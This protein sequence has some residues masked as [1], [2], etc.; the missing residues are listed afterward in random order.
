MDI[1]SKK[2]K[3]TKENLVNYWGQRI[4][5]QLEF[6]KRLSEINNGEYRNIIEEVLTFINNNTIESKVISEE[7]ALKAEEKMKLLEEKAK[8]YEV[9]CA[10]HAHIDMN[11]QWRYDETVDITLETFRTVLNLMEEYKEFTFSQSQASVYEITADHDPELLEE[12]KKKIKENRW[13]VTA[14]SWVE[15]DKNIPNGESQSRHILYTKQYL[16]KLLN[17]N[18]EELVIDFEPDTFG[19]NENIPEILYNGNIKY[20]YFCRGYDEQTLFRWQAP[21]GK[22]VIAYREPFWYNAEINYDIAPAV[23]VLCKKHGIKSMLKVYG[24]G[25]HGGGPTKRDIEKIKDMS[26][27]P[28]YPVF[29]MGFIED[30]FKKAE[31]IKNL[32]EV[33]QELNYIFT[34]CYTSQSRIKKANKVGEDTLFEAEFYNSLSTLITKK[35]YDNKK[36]AD[37]WKNILFNQFHD[38]LPG[39]GTIDTREHAMG[40]FQESMAA[41][42]SKRKSALK[43]ITQCIDTAGLIEKKEKPRLTTSEGAGVGFDIENFQVSAAERGSGE[44]RLYTI[45][46]PTSYTR[47]ETVELTVWD[48]QGD[49]DLIKFFDDQGDVINHQLLEDGYN[50]YWGHKYFRVLIEVKIPGYGYKVYKLKEREEDSLDTYYLDHPRVEP[51]KNYILENNKIKAVIDSTDGSLISLINKETGNEFF[52]KPGGIF[53]FVKEDE[54]GS[55]T[56]WVVGPY[57]EVE[58]IHQN[59]KIREGKN[60]DDKKLRETII[61]ETNFK[62]SKIKTEISLDKNDAYINYETECDWQE[63]GKPDKYVPQLNYYLPLNY[64]CDYYKYNIPYGTINRVGMDRD[65]PANSFA[66]G[67]NND[68]DMSLMINT[69]GKYGFRAN[70][71][72]ISITLIR[73][74]YD[75]DPYPEVGIH[76]FNFSVGFVNNKYNHNFI[77]KTQL[78]NHS[79]DVISTTVHEGALPPHK[80]FLSYEG[81][82]AVEAIKKPEESQEEDNILI[83]FYET[84]GENGKV[85]FELPYRVKKAYFTDINENRIDLN[86]NINIKGRQI[87]FDMLKNSLR[88]LY[89]QLDKNKQ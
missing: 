13:E 59:V 28:I 89:I 4:I 6:A 38:I 71:D 43:N 69:K 16:S 83:R 33:Q 35:D 82:I 65:V 21:S 84:E 11:W 12:I 78:Y 81:N 7:I 31:K 19:H 79:C 53:R 47:Y 8:S 73:G 51:I 9:I 58:S 50:D 66:A 52:D 56:A 72:S 30:F 88:N 29:K 37:S 46:N 32:P 87:Q 44:N 76:N 61:V 39:S 40:L 25:D 68:M 54:N 34:G 17:I 55:G 42:N 1:V 60:A 74:S 70:N 10:A 15:T 3:K 57:K 75:P 5:S 36:F 24:I 2:I 86:S 48:W 63:Q 62:D 80:G 22:S 41:A 27:W 64:S 23:P 49:L 85:K 14:S 26:S 18:P 45:F 67:I 77:K 20:Y